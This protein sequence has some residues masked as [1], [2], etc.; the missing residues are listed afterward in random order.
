MKIQR[1]HTSFGYLNLSGP[2]DVILR[3]YY[4]KF[5]HD[6]VVRLGNGDHV[7]LSESFDMA[8]ESKTKLCDI[9]VVCVDFGS[10]VVIYKKDT[11]NCFDS[12]PIIEIFVGQRLNLNMAC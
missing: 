3:M 6:P 8:N 4:D 7:L 5:S 10:S 1:Q 9:E 2:L 11:Y 12:E